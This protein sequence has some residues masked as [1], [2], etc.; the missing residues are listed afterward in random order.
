M[1]G[2]RVILWCRS[3]TRA[4]TGRGWEDEYHEVTWGE[5]E[6]EVVAR[7]TARRLMEGSPREILRV[8]VEKH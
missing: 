1:A 8:R 5:E 4:C 7:A 6:T 2:W 3:G